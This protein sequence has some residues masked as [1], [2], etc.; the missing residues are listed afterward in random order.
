NLHFLGPRPY[1][2]VPAYLW[3][4]DAAMIPFRRNDPQVD[5][6]SPLKLFQYLACGLPTASTWWAELDGLAL[7]PDCVR[8]A[9]DEAAFAAAVGWTLAAVDDHE[10]RQAAVESAAA[11]DWSSRVDRLLDELGLTDGQQTA[12]GRRAA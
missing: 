5:G 3:N 10:A 8:F 9:R 2:A 12:F 7:P 11:N 1:A 6:V 4:A